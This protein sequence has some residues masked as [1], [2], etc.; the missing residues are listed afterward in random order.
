MS[1]VCAD[2][3]EDPDASG[4]PPRV[5]ENLR[6]DSVE[7]QNL[8]PQRGKAA[9]KTG[10]SAGTVVAPTGVD[11]EGGA[12]SIMQSDAFG[13]NLLRLSRAGWLIIILAAAALILVIVLMVRSAP[14]ARTRR[15]LIA[16]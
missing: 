15:L 2:R 5:E 7:A 13:R 16:R 12:Q 6:F 10:L 14:H 1:L 8:L 9:S 11:L 4:W 3:P